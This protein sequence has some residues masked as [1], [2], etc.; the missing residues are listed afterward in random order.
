[1][2]MSFLAALPFILIASPCIRAQDVTV[3]GLESFLV[4]QK[5]AR[6]AF[7]YLGT[8][9]QYGGGTNAGVDCSGLVCAVFRKAAGTE[10]ART[11]DGL[12]SSG[13][14]A[15]TPLRAGDLLFFDTDEDQP[16]ADAPRKEPSHVGI[17]IGNG[18]FIHAASKGE[19]T[20][21]IISS[22]SEK[23]YADRFI[24]ARRLI[25]WKP[26]VLELDAA[27]TFRSLS[28]R[29]PIPSRIPLDIRVRMGR[30]VR[31]SLL[32][33]S[34]DGVE[35]FTRRLGQ[36]STSVPIVTLPGTWTLRVSSPDGTKL[37]VAEFQVTEK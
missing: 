35:I 36:T 31:G 21:V 24:G 19:R 22:L 10:V 3:T 15:I 5:V 6:E 11:T 12:F 17:F 37:L 32:T 28:L 26:P 4:P 27:E 9:Y 7:V 13:K 1:M 8:P 2:R 30:A 14:P 23:Y 33:A 20:G 25:K 18:E 34:R 16:V 29:D